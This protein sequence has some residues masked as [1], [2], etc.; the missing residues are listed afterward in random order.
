MIASKACGLFMAKDFA[1]KTYIAL[2]KFAD[3]LRVV[4]AVH[5]RSCVDSLNPE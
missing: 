5:T 3:K 1:V 4:E 2:C